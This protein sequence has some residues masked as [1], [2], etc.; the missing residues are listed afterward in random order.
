MYKGRKIGVM[1]VLHPKVLEKIEWP[2][3][4]ALIEIDVQCLIN[5]F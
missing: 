2:F 1:G 5:D 4:A 3:P